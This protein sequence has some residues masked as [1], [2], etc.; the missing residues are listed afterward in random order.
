VATNGVT[1]DL[2]KI[3]QDPRTGKELSTAFSPEDRLFRNFTEH[4]KVSTDNRLHVRDLV[5]MLSKDGNVR[6]D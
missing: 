3:S 4:N 6:N 1:T 5:E 2:T